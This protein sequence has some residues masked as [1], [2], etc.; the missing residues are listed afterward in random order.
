MEADFRGLF[1]QAYRCAP[2]QF[3]ERMFARTLFRHAIPFSWLIR[4]RRSFFR[5]DLEMLRDIASA[6]STPEVICELNR[7]YGRNHRDKNFVRTNFFIRVSGKRV[8]RIYRELVQQR[9]DDTTT[10]REP[11]LQPQH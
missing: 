8:L 7:F 10:L 4:D 6:R 3:E 1:S 9:A 2:E 5:E 11:A